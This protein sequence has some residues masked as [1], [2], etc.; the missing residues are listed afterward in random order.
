MRTDSPHTGP[1]GLRAGR[2]V[3]CDGGRSTVRKLAGFDFPGTPPE[4][5]GYQAV[6]RLTGAERLGTGWQTTDAGTYVHGPFPA[7]CSPWSST[8]RRPTGPHRSPPGNWR[9]ACAGCRACP[10]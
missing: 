9:R 6:V 2:L 5:T 3:G 8:A 10:R 4:I 7:A 1:R